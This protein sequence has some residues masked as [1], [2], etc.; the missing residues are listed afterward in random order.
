[1]K[2]AKLLL[3]AMAVM[4]LA[5][6]SAV[7]FSERLKHVGYTFKSDKITS[8][9]RLCVL[10]DLHSSFYGEDQKKL[11]EMVKMLNPD[12]VLMP[13]D[14]VDNRTINDAAYILCRQLSGRFPCI[15]VSGNHEF[16]NSNEI[17]IKRRLRESG[18]TV[19]EGQRL[20]V[21]AGNDTVSVIGI[22][23]PDI[24]LD[25]KGR[26][27]EQQF[28][29]VSASM[30]RSKL[31]ILL[32]HR[33]E[34]VDFYRETNAD[35]ILAGHAHGGQVIIPKLINGLYSPHQG[36]FPKYAGGSYELKKG[37]NLVVSR[38]L[39]KYNRPRVF[40]RPEVVTVDILPG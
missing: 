14:M 24:P 11:I 10:S 3:S 38:G 30:D 16:Y 23:D 7:A 34:L 2:K 12:L 22:D 39:S 40:N 18:V 6:G 37:Q 32:T 27:W 13:G 5:G 1:M 9:V 21:M 31:N 8:P 15:F 17:E 35:I 29:D 28:E 25:P 33:P 20:D 36:M 26:I 4:A 19:L